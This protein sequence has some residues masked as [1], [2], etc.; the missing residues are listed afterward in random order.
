MLLLLL[1]RSIFLWSG[2]SSSFLSYLGLGRL[3]QEQ[4]IMAIVHV[5]VI[6]LLLTNT[7]APQAVYIPALASER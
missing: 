7:L 2:A 5:V 4:S 3:Q 6:V 1:N